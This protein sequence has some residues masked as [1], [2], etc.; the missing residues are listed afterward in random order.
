MPRNDFKTLFVE[1]E[2]WESDFLRSHCQEHC[3]FE[4]AEDTVQEMDL[5]PHRDAACLSPFIHSQVTEEVLEALPNLRLI[6]TRSTGVDHIAVDACRERDITVC[7]VPTYGANTVAEHTFALVLALTRRVH[8]AYEQTIRGRFSIEG[9]R[10][11]DLR[12]RTLGV[13][14]TG[15]IGTHVIRIA[16][17]FQMRVLAYDVAPVAAMADALGFRYV[18]LD[19]LLAES[20]IVTLHCPLTDENEHMIDSGA[21]G[22]MKD[23]AILINTARGGLVDTDALVQALRNGN[24]AGAGLDV[25]EEET[26]I[27]EEGEMLSRRY[28]S[29]ALLTMVQNTLLLRMD[30]VIVTP[31]IGFN[32]EEAVHKIL[33][34][35]ISNVSSFLAGHPQNVVDET[36]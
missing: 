2:D 12:D 14:G 17:G 24:L 34:T 27:R 22:R 30:N 10:G 6:T 8:K 33:S 11:I 19:T 31:H 35:T 26:A 23:D 18:D 5:E 20:D 29:G 1:V 15:S 16:L 7:N 3:D 36:A 4:T 28:D 25:L 21:I 32:S 9:L 13:V